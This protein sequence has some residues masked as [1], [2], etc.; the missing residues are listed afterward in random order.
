MD[1]TFLIADA[2]RY[3]RDALSRLFS[4]NGF[5]VLAVANSLDFQFG[6]EYFAAV[7]SAETHLD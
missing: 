6:P 7:A 3:S 1:T 5:S 2:D 4:N